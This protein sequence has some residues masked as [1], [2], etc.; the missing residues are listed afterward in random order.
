[1]RRRA[2]EAPNPRAAENRPLARA[3][4]E[5]FPKVENLSHRK[6]TDDFS[7]RDFLAAFPM[8]AAGGGQIFSRKRKSPE[9]PPLPQG[10]K[11][12]VILWFDTE[13]YILPQSDDAAKRIAAFLTEQGIRATF[14]VVG[15][16]ARELER[17]NRR[18]VIGA[19]SQHEIGYHSNTHSQHP[20]VAE[21]ESTLNWQTGAEE[22]T[23][24]ERQGFDRVKRIFDETPSCYGQPG[25][26]WAP[27]AYAA[28]KDWGVRV[29]LDDGKQ[30]GL[31]GRPFWY[32]GL[33]NI[34]NIRDG[35]Q[36]RP[37]A[38][39]SNLSDAKANFQDIHMRLN[40]KRQ[41]GLISLYFHPCEFVHR[42]F[43]DA[44]NF[45]HGSNP[46]R[47]EWKQ[48]PLKSPEESEKAFQYFQDL[49]TFMKSFPRVEFVTA[50]QTLGLYNDSAQRRVYPPEDVG[51]I[52]GQVS[53]GVS[54]QEHDDYALNL[55]EIF[56]LLNAFVAQTVEK[57][58]EEPLLLD[59]A[60]GGPVSA[61]APP[62]AAPVN[63]SWDQFGRTVTDV[64]GYLR[65]FAR[66]PNAVWFGS[67]A[68]PPESYL[69]A[70]AQVTTRLVGKGAIPDTVAVGPAHL[71]AAK[72]VADDS[73]AIWDWVIF[74]PGFHAPNL[75]ELGKLQTWTLKPARLAPPKPS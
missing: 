68:V 56:Y 39:W 33:L 62:L 45:A 66:I 20:T 35:N 42:E 67:Q 70:L 15:E 8:L 6:K 52:A 72:Y 48:P 36:L 73:A 47:D 34:F 21:Y 75:I 27:Q 65:K 7:R 26:A 25:A 10:G 40:S 61:G 59:N 74:P 38:T 22:F 69:V 29:Y 9:E 14:K 13:D 58:P 28:L 53:A 37:D 50:S 57:T 71:A 3:G 18:D 24:R 32:G 19:L 23:R 46:P 31:D 16:K 11:V 60:P 55:A 30:L 63:I 64:A 4:A 5:I 12:Y 17:R 51:T 54:F 2:S 44:V 41:G 49:V 43:W 1:M